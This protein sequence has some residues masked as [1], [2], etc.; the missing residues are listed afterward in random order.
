MIKS[1]LE[2]QSIDAQLRDIEVSISKSD[3]RKKAHAANNFLK[4]VNESIAKLEQ[5][6]EDLVNKHTQALKTYQKLA[7]EVKE[8]DGVADMDEDHLSYVKKKA[9]ELTD[10]INALTAGIDQ[11]SK[12]IESVLKEFAQLRS[13]TKKAKAQLEEFKPKYEALKESKKPE[14]DAIKK[15]LVALEKKIDAEILEKYKQRRNDKIFPVLNE[16]SEVSK[17][18]YCRCGTELSLTTYNGLKGGNIVECESCHR[19]LYLSENK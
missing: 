18:A 16:A 10:E 7:E 4:G 6:A 8:Y 17:H 15:K 11:I 14:M 12:E 13:D 19:L 9:Q 5:R 1:L 3:E 2:Y